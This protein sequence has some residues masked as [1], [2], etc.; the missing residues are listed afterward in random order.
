LSG[1]LA[2]RVALI[3]GATSGIGRACAL[4]FAREGAAIVAGGIDPTGGASLVREI[5]SL[6]GRAVY[7]DA[8]L[9]HREPIEKTVSTA[10][11]AFRQVDVFVSNAALGTVH[12]GGTVETIDEDRWHKALE[13]NLTAS[14]R[15]CKL[16]I[17]EMRR[18]GGGSIVL[19]SS[20]SAFRSHVARPSHA[21]VTS[22]G[23]LL[24]LM[25]GVAMSYAPN[26]IRCNAICPYL[27]E[28]TMNRDLLASPERRAEQS[29]AIPLG[30]VGKPEDVAN[31]ALFLAS[32]DSSF[33]TGQ[34]LIVDGGLDAAIQV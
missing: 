25:R 26:N 3:T 22:K 28:T 29:R 8:D 34:A 14:Y 24:S 4:T 12:V 33:I 21:Y 1:K 11:A 19:M 20:Y 7:I 18:V 13:T 2:G 6:G 32:D 16:L 27:I 10:L 30:R 5:E 31:A 9:Q 17:P 23:A 15:F